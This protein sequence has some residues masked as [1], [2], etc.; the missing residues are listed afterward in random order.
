MYYTNEFIDEIKAF[1]KSSF[2]SKRH[3]FIKFICDI[4]N[5]LSFTIYFFLYTFLSALIINNIHGLRFLFMFFFVFLLV[6]GGALIHLFLF[7]T[8]RDFIFKRMY[9]SFIRKI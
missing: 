8:K 5:L 6:L 7:K 1:K 2:R 9:L 3:C 4:I